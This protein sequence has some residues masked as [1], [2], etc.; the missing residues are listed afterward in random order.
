MS[1]SAEVENTD[2]TAGETL[3]VGDGSLNSYRYIQDAI[4]DA[5]I[6]DT[7]YVHD[8]SSPYVENVVISKAVRLIGENKDTT[9]IDGN[10]GGTVIRIES[11]V[12]GV[13]IRGF[14]IKNSGHESSGVLIM[15]NNNMIADN[16]LMDNSWAG[17]EILGSSNNIIISNTISDNQYGLFMV[18]TSDNKI[19]GNTFDNEF[20][21]MHLMWSLSTII[22]D[23]V[24]ITK[25]IFVYGGLLCYWN[26]HTIENNTINDK[27]IRYYKNLNKIS[28]PGDTA[29]VIIT[30]CI[31]ITIRD[32]SLSK[33]FAAVLVGF[34]KK[35]LISNN[36]LTRNKYGIYTSNCKDIIIKQN[37][38]DN[39]HESGIH[40]RDSHFS[41]ITD[42]DL[43]YNKYA[44]IQLG[45]SCNNQISKNTIRNS[46]DGIVLGRMEDFGSGSHNN[47]ISENILDNNNC[48]IW[49]YDSVDSVVANN[50]I[51]NNDV[52]VSLSS[53]RAFEIIVKNNNITL[54]GC[55]I[56]IQ[57]SSSNIITSNSVVNNTN[58]GIIIA[59][60]SCYN[61]ISDNA[62]EANHRGIYIRS[63]YPSSKNNIIYH[64][65]F[66][67]NSYENAYDWHPN[68]WYSELLG[69]GNYW[70]DYTGIDEDGDGI[71]DTP[72]D[73][74]GPG[75]NQDIYP[76]MEPW[77]L[78]IF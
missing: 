36:Y 43:N 30:N 21:D 32:L 6:G 4:D 10:E 46:D 9:I 75:N 18:G 33:T 8:D 45:S 25:G 78:D 54:N 48:G 64:N 7:I 76:L 56:D 60:G 70:D 74:P 5:S 35:I 59:S 69:H 13:K 47:L 72:Y 71:G 14:T 58:S 63:S 34:S 23:N 57:L 38:I 29:Q 77:P 68:F 22:R 53:S 50:M 31:D 20:S 12:N 52:G 3:H 67:E 37:I 17:I 27:P 66:K 41:K 28:V 16:H 39:N 2:T 15:S 19:I 26:S 24:F 65:N 49:I 44:S 42:N 11:G 51:T 55:G 1:S 61:V 62:I 73:I 40:L